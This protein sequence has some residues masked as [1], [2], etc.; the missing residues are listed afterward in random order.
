MHNVF[1]IIC[2]SSDKPKLALCCMRLNLM[3]RQGAPVYS[4]F[5]T[6]ESSVLCVQIKYLLQPDSSQ[7]LEH[8]FDKAIKGMGCVANQGTCTH[9][10]PIKV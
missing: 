7:T 2:L 10:P 4:K 1:L 3:S 5:I 8:C 6:I 9:A